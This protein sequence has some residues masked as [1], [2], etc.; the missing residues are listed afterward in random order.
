MELLGVNG[1]VD[2]S[3]EDKESLVDTR[4]VDGAGG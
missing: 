3:E 4:E 1:I 2:L